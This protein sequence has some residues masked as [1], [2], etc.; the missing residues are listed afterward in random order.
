MKKSKLDY[1]FEFVNGPTHLKKGNKNR[2]SLH[3]KTVISVADIIPLE[4]NGA[5]ITHAV[6]FKTH[7]SVPLSYLSRCLHCQTCIR[8]VNPLIAPINRK[9]CSLFWF[10]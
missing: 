5:S 1:F 6:L 9:Q 2:G 8:E 10:I 4:R 7:F 3:F